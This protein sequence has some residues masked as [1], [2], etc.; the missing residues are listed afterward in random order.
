MNL[1][2]A[3]VFILKNNFYLI[4]V[5]GVTL[6]GNTIQH[7]MHKKGITTSK[8]ET[9]T[10][11]EPIEYE[12]HRDK[13]IPDLPTLD[14]C[15]EHLLKVVYEDEFTVS[16]GN[17]LRSAVAT[18][19][20]EKVSWCSDE[21]KLTFHTIVFVDLDVMSQEQPIEREWLHWIVGNI[22]DDRLQSGQTIAEY[23]GPT[24]MHGNGTH[25]YVFQ[26]FI[27]KKG[28]INFDERHLVGP[29]RALDFRRAQFSSRE[30]AKKYD[31][32]R[33]YAV[34]YFLITWPEEPESYEEDEKPI[35]PPP[36]PTRDH[37][38][39]FTDEHES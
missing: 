34:N 37:N 23:L 4:M 22:P 29:T 15:P 31:L 30:F 11:M 18:V 17:T 21:P 6:D 33:P 13:I 16:F 2:L 24:P 1:I 26:L 14:K 28:K 19:V 39:N 32:G 7:K 35:P 9:T 8:Y 12:L 10:M 3:G 27:K 38:L 5:H 36:L 20:P 25:R